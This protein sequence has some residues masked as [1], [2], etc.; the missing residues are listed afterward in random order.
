MKTAIIVFVL[1][2]WVALPPCF[3]EWFDGEVSKVDTRA[4]ELIITEQDPITEDEEATVISILSTTKFSGVKSL[5]EIKTGDEVSVEVSY[6][7]LSD[8]W[9]AISVEV[10]GAGA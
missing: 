1:W 3:S 10:A 4:Q 6:D 2:L 7:E 8:S 9:Q 5:K